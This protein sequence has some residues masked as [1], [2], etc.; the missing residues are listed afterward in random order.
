MCVY[1]L[2]MALQ[3][4]TFLFPSNVLDELIPL[5]SAVVK[6]NSCTKDKAERETR[7]FNLS[8]VLR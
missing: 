6:P 2:C 4:I 1:E 8:V 7:C 5:V 3:S